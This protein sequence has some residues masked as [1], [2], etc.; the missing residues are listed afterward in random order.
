[1]CWNKE[2]HDKPSLW[3]QNLS[4]FR[5]VWD[6]LLFFNHYSF[7]FIQPLTTFILAIKRLPSLIASIPV[8]IY[9]TFIKS[10]S[11]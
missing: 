7:V 5:Q 2:M 6:I 8:Y 4:H 9:P 1:M 3:K 11:K 10:I